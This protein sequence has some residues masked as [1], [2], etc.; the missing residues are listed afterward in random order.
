M[1]RTSKKFICD[2]CNKSFGS[3]SSLSSHKKAIH[4]GIQSRS[5]ACEH[6]DKRFSRS[7][8]LKYHQRTHTGEKPYPC[9]QCDKSFRSMSN[10]RSHSETHAGLYHIISIITYYYTSLE[11]LLLTFDSIPINRTII[12]V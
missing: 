1:K 2:Q 5:Y 8:G 11:I 6:C 10:L 9:N 3:L 7:E 12:P 4:E